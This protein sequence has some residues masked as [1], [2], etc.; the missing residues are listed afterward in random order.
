MTMHY[1]KNQSQTFNVESNQM[2]SLCEIECTSSTD[3]SNHI[4]AKHSSQFN[5]QD[6]EFQ[7]SSQI[8]LSKHLNLRHREQAEQS[9]DTHKCSECGKQFS[10]VWN[11][12][13]HVRDI[14]GVKEECS[15]LKKGKCKYPDKVCWKKHMKQTLDSSHTPALATERGTHEQTEEC[16][17]CKNKF[18]T[19]R[20]LMLHRLENHPEKVMPCRNPDNCQFETCWYK[21]TKQINESSNQNEEE[22]ESPN[23]R[24]NTPNP[25]NFQKAPMAQKPP[26]KQNV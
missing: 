17:I 8:I 25:V 12:N 10:A 9:E 20:D 5:C 16:Y 1:K 24:E 18:R 3:L 11:L 21:H 7:G 15:Y 22:S 4:K 6:C 2:C 14:H 19:K 26:E 23:M 13:N